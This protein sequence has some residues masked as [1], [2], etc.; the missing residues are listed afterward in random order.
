MGQ[1][2][3]VR[4]GESHVFFPEKGLQRL[5]ILVALF[6]TA[7]G[8]R[9]YDISGPMRF[10]PIRQY[11]S[12]LIARAVYFEASASIPAWQKQVAQANR[13][14][15]I[16]PPVMEYCAAFVYTI[17]GGEKLWIP[18]VLSIAFWL[19]GG[20]LVYW[21]SKEMVSPDGAL[22]SIAYYLFVPFGVS[23]SRSFQPES[24]MV[25]LY[26]ATIVAI[27]QYHKQPSA[28]RLVSAA[29][30][31]ALAI[32]VKPV[33][34]FMIF[35][36]FFCVRLCERSGG[37]A[38]RGGLIFGAVGVLPAAAY[39]AHGMLPG[40]FLEGNADN[41]FLPQLLLDVSYWKGWLACALK[42]VG[43]GALVAGLLGVLML[44][45]GAPRRL[46]IGMW[47]GYVVFGVVFTYHIHTHDYYSLLLVPTV[48]LSLG[49]TAA[50]LLNRL[51]GLSG[52]WRYGVWGV[53][54]FS[55]L[56][57]VRE[58]RWG[59][60][61]SG[62]EDKIEVCEE[63]GEQVRH[64]SKTIHLA[65]YS[66]YPLRYYGNL[67]GHRWNSGGDLRLRKLAGK[68]IP[69]AENELNRLILDCS[70]EYFIVTH[71]AELRKQPDLEE[72]LRQQFHLI[73][74]NKHYL[75]FDLTRRTE[76]ET[77]ARTIP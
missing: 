46:L 12:A 24:L 2:C 20:L 25:M 51:A 43:K 8:M 45:E 69:N 33:C 76:R 10:H 26:L 14:G 6:A 29:C 71:F 55:I 9:L 54:L 62:L 7:L 38:L 57:G 34:V 15:R 13:P 35:G 50:V 16:E 42:V 59:L 41:S 67:A 77:E 60:V 66:G 5:L 58:A 44:R 63:L 73:K 61:R 72:V 21:L 4:S 74:A 47:L 11:H 56:L 1:G 40:G 17:L 27:F 36:A 23:A 65:H 37:K 31:C 70:A 22:V 53:L 64:S 49:P 32:L 19:V 39:Y 30:I 28:F 68:D 75:I 52:L 48:A 18:R 3:I